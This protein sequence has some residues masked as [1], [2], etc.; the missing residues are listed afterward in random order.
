[1]QVLVHLRRKLLMGYPSSAGY[2]HAASVRLVGLAGWSALFFC[3]HV[4]WWSPIDNFQFGCRNS[5][6][7]RQ[8][9]VPRISTHRTAHREHWLDRGRSQGCRA[10][11]QSV[12][13]GRSP[14][15]GQR[16]Q[17]CPA[18]T[19]GHQMFARRRNRP[20]P[21]LPWNRLASGGNC[22]SRFRGNENSTASIRE[23]LLSSS[24]NG[25]ATSVRTIEA[26]Q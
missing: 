6:P 5:G 26:R 21:G 18:R 19:N 11:S 8:T 1:M 15:Y 20:H 23:P 16:F 2:E 17:Y 22:E 3:R 25:M 24:I 12:S 7:I 13:L 9:L 10:P 14:L 4:R